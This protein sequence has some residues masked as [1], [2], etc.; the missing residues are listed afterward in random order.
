MVLF[1]V[2]CG[3]LERPASAGKIP[4]RSSARNTDAKVVSRIIIFD[5]AIF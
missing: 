3:D 5:R 2:T 1:A 4:R